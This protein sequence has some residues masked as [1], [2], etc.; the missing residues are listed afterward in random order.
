[1]RYGSSVCVCELLRRGQQ[2][3]GAEILQK[4]YELGYIPI[5]PRFGF[6]PFLDESNAEDQQGLAQM[7]MLL[8]KRCRMV[9]VCG[10]EVTDNMNTE[11]S[12]ADRLHIICTTLEGLIQI[13]ETK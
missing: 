3:K 5:C 4:D 6:V 7:S 2:S 13:K 10:S 9:V 12:T 1:M 11:I 8:L